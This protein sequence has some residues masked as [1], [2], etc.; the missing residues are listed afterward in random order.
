MLDLSCETARCGGRSKQLP[1][2]N[3]FAVQSGQVNTV[4]GE[5]GLPL[6]EDTQSI[7]EEVMGA[8]VA[9]SRLK[10]HYRSAHESLIT[11]S[12]VKFYDSELFTFPSVEIDSI[13]SGLHFQWVAEGVYEGKGVNHIEA[14]VVADAVVEHFKSSPQLSL[15]VGTFNVAQQLAIQ[16]ELEH[17]RRSDPTLEPYFE[18]GRFEPFFVKNLENIQG[19]ERDVIFLSV[20]YGRA[21]DGRLRYNLGP[22]NGENGWRRLNV[23]TTRARKLMRVFASMKSDEINLNETASIGAGLLKEFLRYAERRNIDSAIMLGADREHGS[24]FETDVAAEL[25]KRGFTV[26]RE[27]GACGY[28][29]DIGITN[30]QGS[31][32]FICGIECDGTAYHLSETARDRDRLRQQVLEA[33]VG[34][35]TGCGPQTGIKT[36]L[37]KSIG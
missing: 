6:Y 18:K 2:T 20:T 10:W 33:Q 31:G 12:N 30:A 26:A 11:F 14:G 13:D 1:P 21:A 15:G 35:S 28:R 29:I 34:T 3:F 22:L 25:I 4:D 36:A 16:D 37:V 32:R 7:L 8:G 5:D 19:D 23:L 27:I 24:L 9:Q 17:R